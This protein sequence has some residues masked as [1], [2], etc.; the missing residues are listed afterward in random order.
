[1][2]FLR[3][4]AILLGVASGTFTGKYSQG[5]EIFKHSGKNMRIF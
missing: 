2:M 4:F 5:E 1:M 3:V